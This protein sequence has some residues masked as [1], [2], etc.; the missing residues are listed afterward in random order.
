[1]NRR[2]R[3][4]PIAACMFGR[5]FRAQGGTLKGFYAYPEGQKAVPAR[6][7]PFLPRARGLRWLAPL[8]PG[9]SQA[10]L[11]CLVKDLGAQVVASDG[12]TSNIPDYRHTF[13]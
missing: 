13:W 12:G 4:S 9:G 7:P 10:Q 8:L 3:P 6:N 1:M 2:F 11:P 5:W